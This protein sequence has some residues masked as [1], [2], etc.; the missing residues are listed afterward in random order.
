MTDKFSKRG[1]K[2]WVY[3][4]HLNHPISVESV[5][6]R[7]STLR[8]LFEQI[9]ISQNTHRDLMIEL[10]EQQQELTKNDESDDNYN[11]SFNDELIDLEFNFYRVNRV[12]FVLSLYSYLENTLNRFCHQKQRQH[13]L[14]ISVLDLYGNGITRCKTYLEKFNLVNFSDSVCNGAWSNLNNL[15]KLRNSLAHAEGDLDHSRHLD[16]GKVT[17]I[18]GL[19]LF[20][21]TVIISRDY[22][23][24]TMEEVEKFLVHIC[25]N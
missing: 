4:N 15:N 2:P 25:K 10:D 11:Y 12:S 13:D 20:G 14:P 5:Q 8:S 21:T 6:Y 9:E 7:I 18:K 24:D 17:K 16:S 23:T 19:T 3:Q 22:V 1:F